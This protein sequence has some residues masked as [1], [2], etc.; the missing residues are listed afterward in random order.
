MF[1]EMKGKLETTN[2]WTCAQCDTF[3]RVVDDEHCENCGKVRG[4]EH[5]LRHFKLTPEPMRLGWRT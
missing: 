2:E 5:R 4:P 3:N 1:V